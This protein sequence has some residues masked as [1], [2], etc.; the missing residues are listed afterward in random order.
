MKEVKKAPVL[1][2]TKAI[3]TLE[4]FIAIKKVTQCNAMIIPV[5]TNL[6]REDFFILKDVLFIFKNK[7]INTEANSILYHTKGMASTEISLPNMAVKPQIK[8]MI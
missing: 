3:E 1:I 6:K 4:T 7:K 2:V 8:T 5:I